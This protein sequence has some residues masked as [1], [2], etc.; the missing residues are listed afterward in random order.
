MVEWAFSGT[1]LAG[2]TWSFVG[3][4]F[5]LAE[6]NVEARMGGCRNA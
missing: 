5:M 1:A 2:S 4:F 6:G 3:P